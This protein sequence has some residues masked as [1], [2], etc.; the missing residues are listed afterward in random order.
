MARAA[1]RHPIV[2]G[3]RGKETRVERVAG[4]SEVADFRDRRHRHF[5]NA[6]TAAPDAGRV[7]TSARDH[8]GVGEPLEK[9]ARA[10]AR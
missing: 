8:D 9:R 7:C 6:F 4:T 3:Q 5:R 10:A 1:R 2:V